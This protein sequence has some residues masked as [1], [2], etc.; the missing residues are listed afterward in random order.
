MNDT[1][2]APGLEIKITTPNDNN[3]KK[4]IEKKKSCTQSVNQTIKRL[5]TISTSPSTEG[6]CICI[7][8]NIKW[9]I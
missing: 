1:P 6:I 4:K 2:A 9:T 8:K 7:H 5:N 3:S